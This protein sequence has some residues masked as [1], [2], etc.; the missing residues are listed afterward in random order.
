MRI[1]SSSRFLVVYSGLLT[2]CFTFTVA[3]GM[4]S[5]Q[6]GQ[7]S[8][9]GVITAR[10]INIIEPDGTVR[11]TLSN[12]ADFPGA[13]Y[14]KQES[15][16]PDRREAAGLLF[17]SEEG[18]EQGG[19]IWGAEQLP[20]GSIQN[21]CHLSFDQYEENQVLAVDAG[22]EAKQKFSLIT[23]VDQGEYP[24][25]EKQ[26]AEAR[27]AKL[28]EGQRDAA[29]QEFFGAHRHDVP[30]LRLGRFRDGSSGLSLCD[31]SGKTRLRL[32]VQNDGKST[33][34]FL[35]DNGKV[36]SEFDGQKR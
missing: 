8:T 15:A 9:F 14:H 34:Q 36:E 22:Q 26:Q 7:N 30:R 24:I 18:S 17:M 5:G 33:F 1:L 10:R 13:W 11:L 16:R 6:P 32:I 4:L 2:L 25:V 35:D 21:H 3:S 12:R 23:M 19:L 31:G 27:I 29:W 28:P 20:D